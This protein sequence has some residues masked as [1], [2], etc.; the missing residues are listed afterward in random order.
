MFD[1]S[2]LDSTPKKYRISQIANTGVFQ[3]SMII[4]LISEWA[5]RDK[6]HG[7]QPETVAQILGVKNCKLLRYVIY[8]ALLVAICLYMWGETAEFIYFQF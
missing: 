1:R 3:A 7:M 2:I 5:Q 8:T 4:L 6:Q